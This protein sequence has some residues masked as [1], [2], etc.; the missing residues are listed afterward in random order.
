MCRSPLHPFL[1][2][3]PKCE[4]HL[5]LEGTLA[6]SLLFNLASRNGITLP[7]DDAA[8]GSPSSLLARYSRFTSLDD[9]LHYY[10]VG[11]STLVHAQDFEDLAWNYFVKANEHCVKHAEVFFDPQA[12]TD[13]GV[14]F[15]TILKGF[16]TA[17]TRAR[18]DLGISSLLIPCF[19]R[20][21][22]MQSSLSTWKGMLPDLKSGRLAGIGLSGSE[23]GFPPGCW[24][25]IYAEAERLDINRTAHAGEEGPV[26]YIRE[27]LETCNIQ[28]ID[29]GMKLAEDENLM[30]EVS[31]RNI[32][33]TLC[34]LS[35]LTLKCIADVKELPIR[36]FLDAGVPFSINSDDPSYFV[37]FIQENYCA[38]QEAFDLNVDEWL[39]IADNA[40]SGSWCDDERKVSLK[41]TIAT[42]AQSYR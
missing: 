26:A 40:V 12:H 33:V 22:P 1:L 2:S 39:Q 18:N 42:V 23:K 20:H 10:F 36:R 8:F 6:P 29:H 14:A 3:L 34:P 17:C 38:V 30:R 16:E 35:N 19:L 31:E 11:M 13:R 32:L 27:A 24:S 25:D 37:S 28:R 5:H 21:L 15:E 41:Q 7:N 4:H 9:F